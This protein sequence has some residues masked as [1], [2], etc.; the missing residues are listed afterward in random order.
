MKQRKVGSRAEL[1]P[2]HG[3]LA[4][5]IDRRVPLGERN[6]FA[7]E[8]DRLSSVRVT[9][10]DLSSV[11]RIA[12]GALSPMKGP[13]RAEQWNGVLDEQWIESGGRRYAWAIP[14]S[15]PVTFDE[16]SRLSSGDSA[17]LRDESG[18]LVGIGP[19]A[20]IIRVV[21]RSRAI[22]ATSCSAARCARFRSPSIPSTASTCS[23]RE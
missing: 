16:A 12:D 8:A 15:L 1:V 10:A 6:Q 17:A 21:A 13:M 4:D 18:T 22:R 9:R 23:R 19:I 7:K 14:L 20:S 5:L 11:Y 2:V 3:G